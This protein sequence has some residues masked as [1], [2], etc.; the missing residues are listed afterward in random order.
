MTLLFNTFSLCPQCSFVEGLGTD[1]KQWKQ[2]KIVE[3]ENG[4]VN[5]L[6]V[7]DTHGEHRI[8]ICSDG[9]FFRKMLRYS[10]GIMDTTR[11]TILDIEEMDKRLTYRDP[12]FKN[13]PLTIEVD[14]FVAGSSAEFLEDQKLL[15]NISTACTAPTV[16]QNKNY[17]LRLNGKLTQDMVTLNKKIKLVIKYQRSSG[18]CNP[19]LLEL[20]YDRI[21]ELSKVQ[22]T[23]LLDSLVHPSMQIYVEKGKEAR[24]VEELRNAYNALYNISNMQVVLRIMISQPFPC[25]TNI[26]EL[27]R[28]H[29]V[30]FTRFI[31][32]E[33]ERTPKQIISSFK[34]S[35]NLTMDP[36][37]V[38]KSIQKDTHDQLVVGDFYPASVGMILEPF[39]GLMDMGRY[40]IR[41]SPWCGF[42]TCLVNTPGDESGLGELRSV[43]LSRLFDIDLIHSEMIK[44][45]NKIRHKD[46]KVSLGTMRD[47]R[48]IINSSM[49]P[50]MS[51]YLPTD[52]LGYAID[53]NRR[54]LMDN[55][56][57]DVQFLIVH[58]LMDVASIDMVRRTRCSTCG[59][60]G[61]ATV[62]SCTKCL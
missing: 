32:I 4:V 22:E 3:E 13:H 38:L 31:L 33:V 2:A 51:E 8:T 9:S 56:L 18:G 34:S 61:D 5:Q 44:V 14:L 20:S 35:E 10:P 23:V 26:L 28:F 17:I 25:L 1:K 15:L 41:P 7:C 62:A 30:G 48:K 52:L 27:V 12:A 6:C 24:D 45:L 40:N 43:P 49:R 39:L 55:T 50:N 58:N 36:L 37:E 53:S 29:M 60:S 21:A 47:I 42:A 57:R 19:I 54:Q 46:D 11:N 16:L 59:I